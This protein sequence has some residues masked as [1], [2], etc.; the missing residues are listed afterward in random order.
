MLGTTGVQQ[1]VIAEN[2]DRRHD[3]ATAHHC[4]QQHPDLPR[5]PDTH[6]GKN[7][8]RAKQEDADVRFDRTRRQRMKHQNQKQIYQNTLCT[9]A[10]A[11]IG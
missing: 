5:V 1:A 7:E 3:H 9:F 2:T 11:G 10:A 8:E 4:I 6:G